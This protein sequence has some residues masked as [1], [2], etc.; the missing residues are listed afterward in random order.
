[1]APERPVA[2][3]SRDR[4]RQLLALRSDPAQCHPWDPDVPR[5]RHDCGQPCGLGD[6]ADVWAVHRRVRGAGRPARPWLGDEAR[7][8]ALDHRL[9]A[10]C[11]YP[12]TAGGVDHRHGDGRPH[13]ARTVGG[14]R[15]ALD[16][17][18]DQDVLRRQGTAARAVLLV[19]RLVGR[20]RFLL[21]VRRVDGRLP[22]GVE[23]DL[24]DLHR[25]VV[26][27]L[28]PGPQHPGGE[29]RDPVGL[30]GSTGVVWAPSSSPCSPSMCSSAKA[31]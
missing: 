21:A 26:T 17:G 15:D 8:L 16:D 18:P 5:S 25:L 6:R 11:A 29:R 24:L 13:R 19:D 23:V 2:A 7:H 31:P 3:R 14:V 4:G 1:M 30:D 10:D 20:F 28:V 9:A 27:G 22:S 12:S